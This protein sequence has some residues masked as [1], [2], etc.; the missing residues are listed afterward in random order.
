VSITAYDVESNSDVFFREMADGVC[1]IVC[2]KVGGV[3]DPLAIAGGNCSILGF[4]EAGDEKFWTVAGDNVLCMAIVPWKTPGSTSLVS[5]CEDCE[6]RVF[7]GEDVSCSILEAARVTR[8]Q[9]GGTPGAFAYSLG[10]GTV[11]M[12]RFQERDWRFKTKF[13][14][15]AFAFCDVDFDG[16]QELVCGW[17]NGR[18][19]IRSDA[20]GRK[21]ESIYKEQ[22][23]AAISGI[24][25]CDYRLDGR[26]LPLV[27]TYDGGVRALVALEAMR[28]E[29]AE[30]KEKRLLEGL[31]NEKQRLMQD[32]AAVSAQI[33]Q[34]Q[35]G[36]TDASMPPPNATVT[37]KLRPQSETKSV[38]LLLK[39]SEG[40]VIAGATVTAELLF[41]EGDS[42]FFFA[43]SRSDSL[44]CPVKI[45]KDA[46]ISVRVS[47]F[48]G[49]P[50]SDAFQVHELNFRIPKFLM[51][52][53]VRELPRE[54]MGYVS[55]TVKT[56]PPNLTQW[57]Q[58]SFSAVA[59]DPTEFN[60]SFISMR[61]GHVI[62]MTY[63]SNQSL[64]TLRCDS[65]EISGEIIQD[66]A[67]YFELTDLSVFCDFPKEFE[68]LRVTLA[69]VEQF[70]EVRMKLMTD[71]ADSS[72]ALK[73]LLVRAEDARIIG[74]MR[75]M[76]KMYASVYELNRELL[77]ET[78]KRSNNHN[79]LVASLK[80]V[81]VM[82]Q[83][84][85]RLR[86]GPS[87]AAVIHECREAIRSKNIHQLFSIIQ[88][89]S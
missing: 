20:T 65:I 15:N 42:R 4:N 46:A 76:K 77:G 9:Q 23:G 52:V 2:G 62:K 56:K 39:A 82:I 75:L 24:S 6:I 22:F 64:F 31:V 19:D 70:S 49:T 17:N 10:N 26:E 78:I 3:V 74:D 11:G 40:Y 36:G 53:L 35:A 58:S 87:K 54:P 57:L 43:E 25:T 14:C 16:V 28:D 29:A 69:R 34:Q 73:A 85:G 41:E 27:C 55:F 83:R 12:Y 80:E 60:P 71:M 48:V 50:F 67:A 88:G 32:L 89:H 21:G 13:E 44:S 33:Q 81:N 66:I 84:A 47:A 5:G 59:V 45:E 37:C 8:L 79:E 68:S 30:A 86:V 63:N 1:S 61:D 72:Q 38:E 18:V 51:Y 7:E